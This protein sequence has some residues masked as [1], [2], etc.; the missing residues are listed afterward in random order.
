MI[1]FFLQALV[2]PQNNISWLFTGAV[3][4]LFFE[5]LSL[6]VGVALSVVFFIGGGKQIN[7][8]LKVLAFLLVGFYGLFAVAWGIIDQS[9]IVPIYFVLSSTIKIFENKE[10]GKALVQA[11]FRFFLMFFSVFFALLIGALFV[12]LF[13][14]SQEVLDANPGTMSGVLVEEP[15]QGLAWGIIYF[16]LLA[17]IDYL[18]LKKGKPYILHLLRI[19]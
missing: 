12:Y 14:F 1:L 6:H 17:F 5:F 8:A 11:V 4:I 9:F 18:S 7:S 19:K 10:G 15:Q 2:F 16:S 3:G 13:P